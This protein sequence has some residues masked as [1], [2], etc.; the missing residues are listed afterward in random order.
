MV[1]RK[2]LHGIFNV[3]NEWRMYGMD[4]NANQFNSIQSKTNSID[5][6]EPI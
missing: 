5:R 2:N 3:R 4:D 1:W 6:H